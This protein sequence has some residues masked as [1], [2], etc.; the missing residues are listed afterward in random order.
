MS[1]KK[2]FEGLRFTKGSNP[3]AVEEPKK[4]AT[5]SERHEAFAKARG[6]IEGALDVL[7]QTDALDCVLGQVLLGAVQNLDARLTSEAMI[8]TMAF[9]QLNEPAKE[10]AAVAPAPSIE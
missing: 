7:V 6:A 2:L 8:V 3:P 9:A 5:L 4:P 10:P 1:A